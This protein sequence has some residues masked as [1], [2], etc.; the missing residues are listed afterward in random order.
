MKES[1]WDDLL[2][3]SEDLCGKIIYNRAN[4]KAPLVLNEMTIIFG[5]NAPELV[6]CHL[7]L[8]GIMLKHNQLNES[9]ETL[10]L[11]KWILMKES[12]K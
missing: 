10:S 1:R 5:E 6:K 8:A 7:H 12:S 9:E 4:K 3:E 2:T 11:I